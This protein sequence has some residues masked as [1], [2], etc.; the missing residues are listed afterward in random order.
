MAETVATD[1]LEVVRGIWRDITVPKAQDWLATATPLELTELQLHV[2]GNR[3]NIPQVVEGDKWLMVQFLL[4][5]LHR[6]TLR[7]QR[8]VVLLGAKEL[9]TLHAGELPEDLVEQIVLRIYKLNSP[10][11]VLACIAD[12]VTDLYGPI[13]DEIDDVIDITEDTIMKQPDEAQLKRLFAYKKLLSTL[14]RSVLP[15]TS[16]LGSLS[17]GRYHAIDPKFAP[18]LRDSY[19]Y[20]WRSRELVDGIRD[21]LTS[22]QD[23]YLSMVSNRLNDVMKRLTL[24]ATIFLPIS[25]VAS[26]GGINFTQMPFDSSFAFWLFIA[27]CVLTPVVMLLYFRKKGWL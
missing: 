13:L 19:D 14:R 4:P 7:Q 3:R 15:T 11:G 20:M 8:L 10:S 9:V 18:Y 23:I 12:A 5:K 21:L 1:E 25:F 27:V 17:D 24:V 6:T 26:M 16:M 22:A 2:L